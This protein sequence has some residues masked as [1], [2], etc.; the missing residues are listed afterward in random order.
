MTEP[1]IQFSWE[2]T[3]DIARS[4]AAFAGRVIGS[5]SRYISHGEIQTGLSDD[6][7]QWVETLPALLAA[8]FETL[9]DDRDLLTASL[10]DGTI[11][12]VLILAWEESSRRRFAVLEDMAVEPRARSA[13]VGL[14]MLAEAEK[15]VTDR[16]VEWLFLESGL[17]NH[18]AHRFFER[19]G[20]SVLSHVFGKKL[21]GA[22]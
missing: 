18:G 21:S 6:G 13:G 1:E 14:R 22:T 17:E 8:D 4:A 11:L 7:K 16:G 9:G 20:F 10:P 3:S 12:G 2:K 5:D 15:R 19:N